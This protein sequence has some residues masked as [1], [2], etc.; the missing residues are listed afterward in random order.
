MIAHNLHR[1]LF[2][3]ARLI[4]DEPITRRD[5][6]ASFLV[7]PATAS[8]DISAYRKLAPENLV[9]LMSPKKSWAK[10]TTFEPVFFTP[11]AFSIAE[12][13]EKYLYA[14]RLIVLTCSMCNTQGI[15]TNENTATRTAI[16]G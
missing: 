12:Q 4:L 6:T 11:N 9:F 16:P 7:G 10:S 1:L 15:I 5:I 8:R 2:I 13:A 3:E 14:M